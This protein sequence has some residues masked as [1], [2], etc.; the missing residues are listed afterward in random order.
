MASN[1][2]RN[3]NITI[4]A[5]ILPADDE[6]IQKMIEIK[7]KNYAFI[8]H[9]KDFKGKREHIHLV[10]EFENARE[11]QSLQ[12]KFETW[13]LEKC[14]SLVSS[15]Q[16]LTHKNAPEKEQ[17]DIKSVITN[18]DKWLRDNNELLNDYINDE[19]TLIFE[20]LEGKYENIYDLIIA[21]KYSM[22]W[23]NRRWNI[24]NALFQRISSLKH[25]PLKNKAKEYFND[26]D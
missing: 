12:K 24:V 23:L 2:A 21:N 17:Y 13:H 6:I 1:R 5:D 20:V 14:I 25:L 8:R 26:E 22:E 15:I 10:L 9:N 4:N 7:A 18:N 19:K 16:Y 11:F 3:W